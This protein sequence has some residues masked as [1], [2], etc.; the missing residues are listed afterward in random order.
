MPKPKQNPMNTATAGALLNKDDKAYGVTAYNWVEK[1]DAF[2]HVQISKNKQTRKG[3]LINPVDTPGLWTPWVD[4]LLDKGIRRPGGLVVSVPIKARQTRDKHVRANTSSCNLLVP[5]PLPSD[6]D[7]DV[8]DLERELGIS[9][10]S[11]NREAGIRDRDAH[12]PTDEDK[13]R[14]REAVKKI[15]RNMDVF[16]RR[17]NLANLPKRDIVAPA[18]TQTEEERLP[19]D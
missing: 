5:A 4:Y 17:N 7:A 12:V 11:V 8:T 9:T 16:D 14:V 19:W 18:D 1:F 10:D 13:A 2:A 3:V 6:F 15:R